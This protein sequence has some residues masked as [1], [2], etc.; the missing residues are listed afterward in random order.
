MMLFYFKVTYLTRR[1]QFVNIASK[2][3]CAYHQSDQQ[4]TKTI[5]VEIIK[6][7]QNGQ[8]PILQLNTEPSNYPHRLYLNTFCGMFFLGKFDEQSVPLRMGQEVL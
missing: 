6:L 5:I 3:V 7:I 8:P 2:Y 4:P 1:C